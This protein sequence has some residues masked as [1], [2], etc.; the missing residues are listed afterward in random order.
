MRAPCSSYIRE[1]PQLVA[2]QQYLVN[3]NMHSV[4]F[5]LQ[6]AP[7]GSI[8]RFGRSYTRKSQEQGSRH[9]FRVYFGATGRSHGLKGMIPAVAEPDLR[10]IFGRVDSQ[11]QE[12]LGQGGSIHGRG[13]YPALQVD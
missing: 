3:T 6:D 4:C 13:S 12:R 2:T 7:E 11:E 8:P 10:P 9:P 5:T 1:P